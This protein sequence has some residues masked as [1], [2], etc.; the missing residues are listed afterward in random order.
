MFGSSNL[1][2][3][4]TLA[5]LAALTV[6]LVAT[7]APAAAAS[8]D[9]YAAIAFSNSTGAYGYSYNCSSRGEAELLALS[10]CNAS[11]ARIVVWVRNGYC[12]LALGNDVGAAGWAWASTASE[13]RALALNEARKYTT[14]VYIAVTVFSGY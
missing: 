10:Y 7:P 12:A 2:S 8:A 13:A 4:F 14:G 5:L 9:R 3:L 1:K 11:D 6:A